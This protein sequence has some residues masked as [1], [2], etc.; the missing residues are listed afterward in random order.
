MNLTEVNANRTTFF[1]VSCEDGDL[2]VVVK[3]FEGAPKE[4]CFIVRSPEI[5]QFTFES[6]CSPEEV[7]EFLNKE[8]EAIKQRI[9]KQ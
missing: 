2:K 5:K 6:V 4:G 3:G 1:S 9:P 8:I 7:I